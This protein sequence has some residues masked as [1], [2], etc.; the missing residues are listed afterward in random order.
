MFERAAAKRGLL[1]LTLA[2]VAP[3][4][5]W[6]HHSQQVFETSTPIKVSGVIAEVHLANPHSTILVDVEER[7][8]GQVRWAIENSSTLANTLRR[9]FTEETLR[10][11]DPIVACGYAPKRSFT[12]TERINE[13][14]S[15]LPRPSWWG[16]AERVITGRLLV[17]TSGVGENWSVYGPLEP[18]RALLGLE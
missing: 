9:G 5:L 1:A 2:L 13:D 3:G 10:V 8:G 15:T 16:T 6:A 18:C 17:L 4:T 12:A 11:G 7:G 14:G